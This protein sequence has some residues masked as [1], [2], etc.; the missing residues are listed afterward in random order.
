M[1]IEAIFCATNFTGLPYSLLLPL[2]TATVQNLFIPSYLAHSLA[3]E[4]FQLWSGWFAL[5]RFQQT[6]LGT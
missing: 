1:R 6:A 2:Q 4:E 5:S 3:L